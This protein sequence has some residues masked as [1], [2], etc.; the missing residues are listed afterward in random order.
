MYLQASAQ[1]K[2]AKTRSWWGEQGQSGDSASFG[3]SQGAKCARTPI[4]GHVRWSVA[5]SR[6]S[7]A[8]TAGMTWGVYSWPVLFWIP[9]KLALKFFPADQQQQKENWVKRF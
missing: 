5:G 3:V 9:C 2:Q 8:S 7:S 1:Q 4:L 6:P